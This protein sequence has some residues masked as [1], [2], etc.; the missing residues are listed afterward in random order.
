MSRVYEEEKIE[1]KN[2]IPVREMGQL[3]FPQ[4]TEL[5]TSQEAE[6]YTNKRIGRSY[7]YGRAGVFPRPRVI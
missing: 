4:V 3:R 7:A 6:D 5:Q 1:G 2:N